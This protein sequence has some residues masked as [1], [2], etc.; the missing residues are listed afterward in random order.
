MSGVISVHKKEFIK[1]NKILYFFR[2]FVLSKI[3]I[4]SE[5]EQLRYLPQSVKLEESAN[6]HIIRLTMMV[7]SV[8]IVV[9]ILW[10]AITNINEITG[11]KGNIVPR[12]LTQV[13]QHL[14]GGIVIEIL[15][16]EGDT[17]STGQTLLKVDD[18]GA[19]ENLA[20]LQSKQNSLLIKSE[21]LY[22]F[23]NEVKFDF[24][25]NH[26]DRNSGEK[27]KYILY[28]NNILKSMIDKKVKEKSILDNQ[29]QQNKDEVEILLAERETLTKTLQYAKESLS[30]HES[31][32]KSG[33][34]S[35]LTIIEY[36][37]RIA[38]YFG[39][40]KEFNRKIVKAKNS[41]KEYHRRLE[42]LEA[43]YQ[44]EAYQELDGVN[45]EI[46]RNK[47]VITKLRRK[48]SRLNVKSPVD[49]IIKG[50]KIN[51]IGSVIEPG[52][53]LMEI[54]PSN[55]QLV[56][57]GNISPRDIGHVHVGQ[58][59]QIKLSSYD[60]SRYGTIEGTL[61]FISATTFLDENGEAYYQARVVLSQQ[62]VG[63]NSN[64]NTVLPGMTVE[65]DIIT[66]KK[67]ILAYLLKPIHVS[68]KTALTER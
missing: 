10:A 49:G 23:I 65:G 57:D 27:E 18:G 2:R 66:G 48:V 63:K 29:L 34:T 54:L 40:I 28:Q 32:E 24:K 8:A 56:V 16:A 47:E 4:Q 3:I 37:Q 41:I 7:I 20:E 62:Y 55:S 12:G 31:L 36:K 26:S 39:E 50:L 44:E 61:E 30:L 35:K 17:V 52:K 1:N 45:V 14:D 22:A 19:I 38:E 64:K 46:A 6:P 9:F 21:R 67:T 15:V 43:N 58:M 13:V 60:F 5:Q 59:V 51:T 25:K 42:Y 11:I 68:L 53:T 33:Y